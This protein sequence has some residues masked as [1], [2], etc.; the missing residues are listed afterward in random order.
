MG[1][2]RRFVAQ[3][4]HRQQRALPLAA[5][6]FF[7]ITS[8]SILMRS[9][10]W[11]EIW[12]QGCLFCNAPGGWIDGDYHVPSTMLQHN[13]AEALISYLTVDVRQALQ[14]CRE[15]SALSVVRPRR[16]IKRFMAFTLP[17]EVVWVILRRRWVEKPAVKYLVSAVCAWLYQAWYILFSSLLTNIKDRYVFI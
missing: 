11:K 8:S 12:A 4:A 16:L 6:H 15:T 13:P 10:V 17:S 7:T 5:S 3:A 1:Q 2:M 14:S 9:S